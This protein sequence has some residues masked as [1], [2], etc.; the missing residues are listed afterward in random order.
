LFIA[1]SA[2]IGQNT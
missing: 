2:M 1:N